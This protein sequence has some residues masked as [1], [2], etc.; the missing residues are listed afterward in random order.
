MII[1]ELI[2]AI[3]SG[4]VRLF[5]I[6][7]LYSF[8]ALIP[9]LILHELG[10]G[11]VALFCGDRTAKVNGR[12]SFN[13]A[14]HLDPIGTLCM[15]LIGFGWAK[16]VP[17]NPLNFRSRRRDM[18]LVSLAGIFVNLILSLLSILVSAIL[19]CI[20]VRDT[21]GAITVPS[22]YRGDLIRSIVNGSIYYDSEIFRAAWLMYVTRFFY[23]FAIYNLTLAVFNFLPIPPLDGYRFWNTLVFKGRLQLDQRVIFALVLSL[24]IINRFTGLLDTVLDS[25]T[26]F[27]LNGVTNLVLLL[28]GIGG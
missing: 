5:L 13:P 18:I 22:F 24:L 20:V 11:Y 3:Q 12:L 6:S 8:L 27:L 7:F 19:A 21:V 4:N 9:A 25:A 2:D 10:H 23:I 1:S 26:T 17:I 28:F 16:P 14:A 15:F